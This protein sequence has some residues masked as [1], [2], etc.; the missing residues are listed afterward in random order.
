MSRV[1]CHVSRIMCHLS[2]VTL[3]IIMVKLVSEGSVIN[4]ANPSSSSYLNKPAAQAAGAD[5]SQ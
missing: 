2:S 5:P 1:M 3:I 4:R